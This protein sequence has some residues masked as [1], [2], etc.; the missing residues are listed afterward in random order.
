[1]SQ[2]IALRKVNARAAF[3]R[4]HKSFVTPQYHHRP[5]QDVPVS[6]FMGEMKSTRRAN[7]TIHRIKKRISSGK[8]VSE[9]VN[10]TRRINAATSANTAMIR[11]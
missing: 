6:Q 11:V 3:E 5:F 7:E 2:N 1:M 8:M 4:W 9:A 10:G